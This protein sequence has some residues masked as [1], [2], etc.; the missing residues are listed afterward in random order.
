MEWITFIIL[1]LTIKS[2]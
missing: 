1:P 2:R